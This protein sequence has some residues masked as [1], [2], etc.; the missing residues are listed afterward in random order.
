M[1]T[2]ILVAVDDSPEAL[3][4]ARAAIGLA[5]PLAATLR[6]VY[7]SSDHVL[8]RALEAASGRP[9]A[10]VRRALAAETV[11]ARVSALAEQAGVCVETEL[12]AGDVGAAILEQAREWRADLV[13][14]GRSS[15]SASGEPY[16]GIQ[17]RHVLEF[18]D[19]PVLV[20]PARHR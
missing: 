20:V 18:A 5:G 15:R 10:E 8:D 14:M 16:V 6:A 12:L 11:L 3:A 13:V 19:Q 4:A 2:R 7:V 17:A 9:A 1:I